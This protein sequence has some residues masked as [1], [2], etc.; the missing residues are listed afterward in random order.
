MLAISGVVVEAFSYSDFLFHCIVIN[1]VI[2]KN[3]GN[4]II[5]VGRV[6]TMGGL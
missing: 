5:K 6:D 3:M 1:P 4:I 2:I